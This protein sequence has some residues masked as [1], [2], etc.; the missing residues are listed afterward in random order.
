MLKWSARKETAEMTA[1]NAQVRIIM[2]ERQKGRTQEQ[3]AAAANLKSRKTAA[4]YEA[5]G[6][7]PSELTGPRTYRTRPD[8]FTDDWS[9]IERMLEAA[10]ELEAKALFEW[11]QDRRPDRYQEGQLRT[12]QRRVSEWRALHVERVAILAQQHRPGEVLQ[13]DGTWLNEFGITIQGVPLKH[14]FIHCVLPYSNWEWGC[15][16]QSETLAALRLG[17]QRTL[18]KLGRVP[19]YHSTDH[20]SAAAYQLSPAA[21]E[22]A[23]PE[24]GYTEGYKQ[25]MAHFGMEPQLIHV[26][27]PQEHGDVEAG[28]GALKRSLEQTLL[29]R[30]SRDFG[31]LTDYEAFL[32]GVLTR[33]NQRRQA[34]LE[35]ELA[36]MKQLTATPLATTSTVYVR[37]SSGSLI[38]VGGNTY[39]VP[40]SLIG[41]KVT[42]YVHEWHLEV[43][44]G[45][46]LVETL[47]RLT[48]T[49][50]QHISYRHLIGT[51]LRKPG[52]FREYRYREALFP[53]LVYRRAWEQLNAWQAPRKADLTYLRILHLAAR[54]L[55]SDVTRILEQLLA[56]NQ[57]WDDREV[58]R[59]LN[60]TPAPP[61]AI[62]RG[63]VSLAAYDHLLSGGMA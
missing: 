36:V 22:Q 55:E 20:T 9:L 5:L 50:Q 37:V 26:G 57:H 2:R 7:L 54:T 40:T 27:A 48:S 4:K 59:R 12:F 25:L 18:F 15:I 38:Q 35:E 61:P 30:G 62:S 17:L 41:K 6:K 56:T 51:L 52:G 29:L 53:S 10:P 28:N 8:P 45:K 34:R 14:L 63:E 58:E 1:T 24:W 43:Y 44:Y 13:T 42:V 46:K 31:L 23:R 49:G 16:A 39:S 3:A 32:E 47:P 11:L 33:R 21:R 60:L 19:K